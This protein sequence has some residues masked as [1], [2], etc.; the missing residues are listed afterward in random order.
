M[1]RHFFFFYHTLLTQ[2]LD[3]LHSYMFETNIILVRISL[4]EK[5]RKDICAGKNCNIFPFWEKSW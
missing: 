4:Q 2:L 1:G 3:N 5:K